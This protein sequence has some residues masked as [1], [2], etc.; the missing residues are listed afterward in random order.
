MGKLTKNEKAVKN[1]EEKGIDA[2]IDNDTVYVKIDGVQLELADFEIS[3]QADEYNS[4]QPVTKKLRAAMVKASNH[5]LD[6][7]DHKEYREV[8]KKVYNEEFGFAALN[9]V[10]QQV[11]KDI[12]AAK[13]KKA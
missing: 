2:L 11:Q 5:I 7:Y 12:L 8:L 10:F 6:N 13:K 4:K 9:S 3:F 1:L